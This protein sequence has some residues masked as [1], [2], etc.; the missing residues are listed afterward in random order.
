MDV[1]EQEVDED[2]VAAAGVAEEIRDGQV[3]A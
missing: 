1:V 2:E 3:G